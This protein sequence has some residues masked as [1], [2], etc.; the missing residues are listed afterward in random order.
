VAEITTAVPMP[1]MLGKSLTCRKLDYQLL[2]GLRTWLQQV[3]DLKGGDGF[4]QVT[5][6]PRIK[7]AKP[8][9]NTATHKFEAVPG[10]PFESELDQTFL[11]SVPL[12][13]G[14]P[15]RRPEGETTNVAR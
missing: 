12:K 7:T 15:L 14:P 10:F 1:A 2:E 6:L 11:K 9:N 5:D 3:K 8:L 4:R 13:K